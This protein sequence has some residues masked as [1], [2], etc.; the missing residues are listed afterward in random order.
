MVLDTTY[1][2]VFGFVSGKRKRKLAFLEGGFGCPFYSVKF[3]MNSVHHSLHIDL[4]APTLRKETACVFEMLI[5]GLNRF[6]LNW[7]QNTILA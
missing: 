5:E 4:M 6:R 7:V 2:V 1:I 3:L